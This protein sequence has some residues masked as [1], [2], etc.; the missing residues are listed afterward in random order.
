MIYDRVHV[1]SNFILYVLR[2]RNIFGNGAR[3]ESRS[4]IGSGGFM[5]C[6]YNVRTISQA[7]VFLPS[8]FSP[9]RKQKL[10]IMVQP[11]EFQPKPPTKRP[12]QR[13]DISKLPKKKIMRV[14]IFFNLTFL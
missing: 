1:Q 9:M 6:A 14:F 8:I 5:L 11:L 4:T 7:F 10:L 12:N 13:S 3:Y 2:G